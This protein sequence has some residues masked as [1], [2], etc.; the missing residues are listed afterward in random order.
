[1]TRLGKLEGVGRFIKRS[2]LFCGVNGRDWGGRLLGGALIG[3]ALVG[4]AGCASVKRS[5][6]E[7]TRPVHWTV[8]A[9][10]SAEGF[11]PACAVDGQT[12]TW[13][14]SG[15][16]E[17]QWLQIDLARPVMVCGFS[18]Q[19]GRPH[20]VAYAVRTSRDGVNWALGFETTAGDGDWD[21]VAL[22]PILARYVR[23]EV[24]RGSTGSGAALCVAEIKGLADRPQ[25]WVNGVLEPQA[26]ALLDGNR[27]TVWR[28]PDASATVDLDLKAYRPVGSVRIDWG[29]NGYAQSVTVLHS[30][31]RVDWTAGGCMQSRA[32]DFDVLLNETVC[33][34][35][36]L[37]FEF[38]EASSPNGFS[39]AEI[40]LRGAE[41]I[42]QPWSRYELAATQA[43][44]GI[45]PDTFR[46]R[47]TYWSVAAGLRGDSP[48]CLLDEWGNFS[49]S[50]GGAMLSPLL[51]ADGAVVSAQQ[52]AKVEYALGAHGAPMPTLVWRLDSGLALRIRALAGTERGPTLARVKYDVINDSL[53]TQTGRLALVA[54]PVRIPPRWAGGG[55]AP[56]YQVRLVESSKGWQEML[57]NGRALWAAPGNGLAGGA[58]AFEQGDA[59]EF[60]RRGEWP[61]KRV[62][63]DEDGL[64]SGVWAMDFDLGPGEAAALVVAA[65]PAAT[66]RGSP[67]RRRHPWPFAASPQAAA[68]EFEH[69]WT[70]AEWGWRAATR[71]YA[72][73]IARS[74]AADCLH[75]QV[76]WLLGVS[77]LDEAS[78]GA[79]MDTAWLRV[80]ALLRAGQAAVAR[81]WIERAAA[82][83]TTNG[84][85]PAIIAPEGQGISS[86]GQEGRHDSQGQF[87]FMVMEYYRYT[88]DLAFLRDNYPA[89]RSALEY[90]R[91]LR[92]ELE[93]DEARLPG[94][95]RD[96]VEGLLPLSGARPGFQQPLHLYA[97]NFWALLAWKEG[98]AA[99]AALGWVDDVRWADHD[100]QKLRAALQRSIRARLERHDGE[101]LPAAVEEDLFDV[102]TVALLL[103]PCDEPGLLEPH[104]IQSSLDWFYADFLRRDGANGSARSFTD[105]GLLL[106][107][108]AG[109]GR[110]DYAREVLYALLGNRYPSGW[111]VW[112][113]AA[114]RD[115]R[116]PRQLRG[117]PDIRAA[118]GYVIGARGLAA[119]E[120]GGRLDL[121]SGAPAEW[122]QHGRGFKVFGM[123]TAF[124]PLD[125]SGFWKGN[126]LS[127]DIGGGA[128]PPEG[129][130]LWWPR[131]I[132]PERVLANGQHL[133]E[134]DAVGA[135]LP[136]DFQGQV[137][138]FFPF[139]APW[140]REP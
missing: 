6:L 31:N 90:L 35:R 131:Q 115:R 95:Q 93:P 117:M 123:P 53:M 7:V 18:L 32:G 78:A 119:R 107:A 130:R 73:H 103:W 55:L 36:Y 77:Q 68:E 60:V 2:T 104:E 50:A 17:P 29:T 43:P 56:M 65:N 138:A 128:R 125:F 25:A 126:R 5:R 98:R 28:C 113:D 51:V 85:V 79:R 72:P 92:R 58:S 62:A 59:V 80:A 15:K 132:K 136:H 116:Q 41:G 54:R 69:D 75:A 122:L 46:N 82:G 61:A 124:G 86:V 129:Y 109:M 66:G 37:R 139:K 23:I 94:D 44:E 48:E 21:Q 110:G 1:M 67:S 96:L 12:N 108:L 133:K 114:A 112:A 135:T 45:Y 24:N 91:R 83:V 13:W 34:V 140:P 102:Q 4:A 20:A 33:D 30:T 101:W 74:D 3:A 38:S 49:A 111:H 26:A 16:S 64:A 89:I 40:T 8:T 76:G 42:A 84:W 121:F 118:A 57:V 105:E 19:W 9:S 11:G 134:F 120:T 52:A 47:Q 106:G 99:A 137:E 87:V 63:T 71:G 88:K 100:Y 14:R 27:D 97:D 39:V 10:E 127:V 22:E 81:E 70:E